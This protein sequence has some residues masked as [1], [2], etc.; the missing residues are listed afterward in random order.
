MCCFLTKFQCSLW[1]CTRKHCAWQWRQIIAMSNDRY[2]KE[3]ISDLRTRYNSLSSSIGCPA[4]VLPS[5]SS[6]SPPAAIASMGVVTER[7]ANLKKKSDD[8]IISMSISSNSNSGSTQGQV[9]S[10]SSH[11]CLKN[12]SRISTTGPGETKGPTVGCVASFLYHSTWPLTLKLLPRSCV[13]RNYVGPIRFSTLYNFR[14]HANHDTCNCNTN[15]ISAHVIIRVL[16]NALRW[17]FVVQ[18]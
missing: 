7:A 5:A 1:K 3:R 9:S 10:K 16:L 6:K 8:A 14:L 17:L 4:A 2:V 18:H 15:Q 13:P 12:A 11:T